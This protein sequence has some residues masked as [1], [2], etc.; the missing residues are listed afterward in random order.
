VAIDKQGR[1]A[2]AETLDEHEANKVKA[3]K[4]GVL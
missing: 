1:S 4:N 2:F 3:R